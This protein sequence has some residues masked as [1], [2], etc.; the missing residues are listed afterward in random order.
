MNYWDLN[1]QKS[2]WFSTCAQA[3]QDLKIV[4]YIAVKD[5]IIPDQYNFYNGQW[6]N[7]SE[8]LPSELSNNSVL[9]L[10]YIPVGPSGNKRWTLPPVGLKE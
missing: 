6:P 2:S 5:W 10:D 1:W 8:S 9:L 3:A 4:S 7:A